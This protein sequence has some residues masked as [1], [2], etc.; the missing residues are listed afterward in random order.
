M[1]ARL[2]GALLASLALAACGGRSTLPQSSLTGDGPSG[3]RYVQAS[4]GSDRNDGSQSHPYRTIAR[5]ATSAAHG[6]T[7]YVRGGTYREVIRPNN[8]VTIRPYGSERVVVIATQRVLHWTRS[9]GYIYSA[10]VAL[11][12][13]LPANQV[14]VGPAMTV[15]P[16]AQWPAPSSD[17]MHPHWGSKP[18]E[19]ARR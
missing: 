7:C 17:P 10:A 19:A 4:G 16:E 5:C 2:A 9:S 1:A 11:N 18:L 8:G 15:V 13:S 12:P 14:F 3:A 6:Q